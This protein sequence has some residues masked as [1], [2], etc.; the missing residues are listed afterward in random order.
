MTDVACRRNMPLE[1]IRVEI[2]AN[3]LFGGKAQAEEAAAEAR[4]VQKRKSLKRIILKGNLSEKDLQI[5]K[6]TAKHC[7]VS[8]LFAAGAMEFVDEFVLER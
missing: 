8:R 4:Q 5:L 7:P 6:N 2:A 1:A 3:P